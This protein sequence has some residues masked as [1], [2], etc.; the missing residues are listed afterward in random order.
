MEADAVRPSL[1]GSRERI[2]YGILLDKAV[3]YMK[4]HADITV[5]DEQTGDSE[6]NSGEG[7]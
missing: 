2:E 6:E 1:E 4:E 5:I 3:D 7:K